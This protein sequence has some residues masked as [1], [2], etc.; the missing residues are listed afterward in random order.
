MELLF[1]VMMPLQLC[2]LLQVYHQVS[3]L[4]N[5]RS[6]FSVD[7]LGPLNQVWIQLKMFLALCFFLQHLLDFA[8]VNKVLAANDKIFEN[9]LAENLTPLMESLSANY[10]H[11]MA[12][13]TT[14]GKNVMPRLA[15]KLD[16]M[17]ISDIIKVVDTNTFQRP[18]YAGNALQTVTA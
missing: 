17:Q 11:I 16:V 14:T 9:G 7:Y 5:L 18:I 10:S 3:K 1:Q 8:N 13:A 15:A 4:M 6:S 2:Q 12:S